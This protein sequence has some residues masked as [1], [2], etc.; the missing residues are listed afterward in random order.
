MKTFGFYFNGRQRYIN[1]D[2]IFAALVEFHALFEGVA[3]D[4]RTLHIEQIG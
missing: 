3:M 4:I 1:A 2:N